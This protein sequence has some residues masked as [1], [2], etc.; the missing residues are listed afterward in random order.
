MILIFKFLSGRPYKGEFDNDPQRKLLLQDPTLQNGKSPPGFLGYAVNMIY[1]DVHHLHTRTAGKG[2][3]ETLFYRLFGKL[4]VYETREHMRKAQAN[5]CI[6]NGAVS[7]DGGI[8]RGN[9]LLTL[10]CWYVNNIQLIY[11]CFQVVVC[12]CCVCY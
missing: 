3:R 8:M 4:Q 7:L 9:G 6:H 10:G 1:I 11:M 2:L 5:S 12:L